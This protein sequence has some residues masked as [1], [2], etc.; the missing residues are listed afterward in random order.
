VFLV[1]RAGVVAH[2]K[3]PIGTLL[4]N[5]LVL[6]TVEDIKLTPHTQMLQL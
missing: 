2:A 1:I 6:Y 3:T 4:D 5:I